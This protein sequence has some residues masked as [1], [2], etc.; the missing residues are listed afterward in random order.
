MRK[1]IERALDEYASGDET[2]AIGIVDYLIREKH[3]PVDRLVG[4][5]EREFFLPRFLASAL[6]EDCKH[7]VN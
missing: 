1:L 2:V 3:I 4:I 7:V 5:L 6:I